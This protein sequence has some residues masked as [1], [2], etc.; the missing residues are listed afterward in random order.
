MAEIEQWGERLSLKLGKFEPDE[1][2]KKLVN[3]LNENGRLTLKELA[4]E[5]G[6]SIDGVK[7]R[8]DKMKAV[9]AIKFTV[10]PVAKFF[11]YPINSQVYV[12][13]QNITE[14]NRKKFIAYLKA[15]NKIILVMSVLGDYDVY[16]VPSPRLPPAPAKHNGGCPTLAFGALLQPRLESSIIFLIHR[17]R[18]LWR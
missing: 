3:L 2:D 11:G 10:I 17:E 5:V 4:K 18:A 13:L 1:K 15:H 8:I 6:M 14:E 12:K 9:G 7:G 16:F